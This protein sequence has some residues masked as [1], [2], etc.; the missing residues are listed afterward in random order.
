MIGNT[1]KL[2]LCVLG[3]GGLRLVAWSLEWMCGGGGAGWDGRG[4]QLCTGGCP[5]QVFARRVVS[6]GGV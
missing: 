3:G 5:V 2:L 6:V 1:G 4:V